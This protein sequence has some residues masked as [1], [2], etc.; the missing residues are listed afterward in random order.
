MRLRKEWEGIS[1]VI[2]KDIVLNAFAKLLK[3]TISFLMSV[4]PSFRPSVCMEHLGSHRMDF[5]NILY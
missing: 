2:V 3:V 1:A 4:R 5:N